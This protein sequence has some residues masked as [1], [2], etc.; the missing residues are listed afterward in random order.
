MPLFYSIPYFRYREVTS[1]V[2]TFSLIGAA[3]IIGRFVEMLKCLNCEF[4]NF[5][6]TIY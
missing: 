6:V 3:S 1:P 4:V 5:F 2:K